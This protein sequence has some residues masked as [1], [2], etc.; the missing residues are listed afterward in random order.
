MKYIK[1]KDAATG[2]EIQLSYKD[3]GKGRPVV[4]IHGWPSSK[5]MWEY[6]I[7]DLVN[8]GLRVVKYDRR[9]F[10]KSDKPWNGYDYDTMTDDLN[11]LLETLDLRD[12]VLVGFSMGGGE[13]VRYLNRY[14]SSGRVSKVILVSAVV[15]YLGQSNDNPEGVPQAVFAEM[16]E[17][18]KEDRIAFLDTFGEQFFG[19]GLL[20]HPVSKPYLQY[21]RGLAEVALP[22]ATQQCAIAFANTDFRADVKAV[23]VPTLIIHGDADKTVPIEASSERTAKMIPNAVYKVYEGAPHGLFY[24]ERKRLNQD[25]IDFASD[26]NAQQTVSSRRDSSV[27]M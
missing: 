2:E 10:G 19:V 26:G 7:D 27:S 23:N 9:G 13:A 18:M 22:R 24:T 6:Q 20:E 15:P 12:A 14:G 11:A 25:I 8:A 16:M 3:Y 5:D 1:T 21:F 17:K 4:L